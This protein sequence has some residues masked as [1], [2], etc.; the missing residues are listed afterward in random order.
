[1]CPNLSVF[2]RAAGTHRRAR[3]R[4]PGRARARESERRYP[5]S[6]APY[7]RF[8]SGI[9]AQVPI[10]RSACFDLPCVSTS[11][12]LIDV[13]E[14]APCRASPGRF[15]QQSGAFGGG[16]D[17]DAAS[18]LHTTRWMRPSYR[19]EDVRQCSAQLAAHARPMR[20]QMH[21]KGADFRL[22][23]RPLHKFC[24]AVASGCGRRGSHRSALRPHARGRPFFYVS[25]AAFGNLPDQAGARR[26]ADQRRPHCAYVTFQSP[27]SFTRLTSNS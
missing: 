6:N 12:K 27:S 22:R 14:V 26:T 25:G 3:A 17:R 23:T 18:S 10:V 24:A 16:S 13:R 5:R 7:D 8:S 11:R 15:A 21:R 9:P 1:M 20:S 19:G 2:T 4:L